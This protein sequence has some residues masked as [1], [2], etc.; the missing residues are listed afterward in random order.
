MPQPV[1]KW[2]PARDVWETDQ[3]LIC[4][5]SDVFS[6]TFPRSGMTRGGL[7]FELPTSGLHMGVSAS[8]LL[9]TPLAAEGEK[10]VASQTASHRIAG[11][12]QP[13]LTNV[14]AEHFYPPLGPATERRA[15]PISEVPPVI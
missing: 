3:G 1:A 13:F 14:V 8:S 11:G 5:H 7:L 6:E 15:D 4:G 12:H 2:N 9:P 10:A